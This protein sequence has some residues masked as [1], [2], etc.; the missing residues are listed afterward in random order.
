MQ[1]PHN[2]FNA[3]ANSGT[4]ICET[5]LIIMAHR[6]AL[7]RALAPPERNDMKASR[8]RSAELHAASSR[9]SN[10]SLDRSGLSVSSI[11]EASALVEI[12]PPGQFGR[13]ASLL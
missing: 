4:F 12:L 10:N 5:M 2:S 13:S 1:Q 3:S 11:C 7:I 6:A 8:K 9:L